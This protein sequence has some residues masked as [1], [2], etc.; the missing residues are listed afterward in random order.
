MCVGLSNILDGELGRRKPFKRPHREV[1]GA[2]V[3]DG[4]L[5]CEVIQGKERVR[6]IEALL[7]LA[8]A[9][10]HF[11]VVTRCIGA[12]QLVADTQLGGSRLKES[13]SVLFA[14]KETVGELNAVVGLNALH[15]DTPAGV[16]LDQLFQKVGRGIGGLLGIGCKET[17]TS[18]F[19]NGGIL[20]QPKFRISDAAAG[21]HLHVHLDPLSRISHLLVGLGF[22][23]WFLFSLRKQA[24]LSHHPEQA[25]RT[26][27]VAALTQPVPQFH[28][29]QLWVPAAHVPDQLQLRLC[30]LVGMAVGPSGLTGQR[31]RRSIPACFPKVD[32]RPAL[33]VF[34]AGPADAIFFCVLHQGLPIC[35]V[36][37]Y[38]L[39]HE[40]YGLLSYSCCPQLQL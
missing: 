33:V 31:L 12:N 1:V 23:G 24:Q 4:K 19:I 27:G 36:L 11:A 3:V 40:G 37:C 13:G 7:I 38:T 26:A 17:Q 10:L 18:K 8:V 14:G 29:A 25:F 5:L 35:H 6:R 16:P 32:V 39:A 30:V 28:H 34:P 9:A 2:A 22:I 21:N 15:S 20:E